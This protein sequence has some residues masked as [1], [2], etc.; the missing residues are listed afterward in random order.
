M[1]QAKKLRKSTDSTTQHS[2]FLGPNL[3]KA[4]ASA[5]YELRCQRRLAAQRR[6]DLQAS[7][8]PTA[9]KS[10]S[11]P[12][13]AGPASLSSSSLAVSRTRQN[14]SI[15]QQGNHVQ[16]AVAAP[17]HPS[18]RKN[19]YAFPPPPPQQTT[20]SGSVQQSHYQPLQQQQQLSWN[21]QQ[22][23]SWSTQ[24]FGDNEGAEAKQRY[25]Q[26]A[27]QSGMAGQAN[28]NG[29]IP[30]VSQQHLSYACSNSTGITSQSVADTMVIPS[31]SQLHFGQPAVTAC[32]VPMHDATAYTGIMQTS[33]PTT[34]GSCS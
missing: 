9:S 13:A 34:D 6:N 3:T 15:V 22:L 23:P 26:W 19:L 32:A 10:Q 17:V 31:Y 30:L 5:A 25:W 33:T 20:W 24:H 29:N 7:V 16:A 27:Q 18:Q 8:H 1:S 14:G 2:I 12:A 11:L 21:Q 4:E 28:G